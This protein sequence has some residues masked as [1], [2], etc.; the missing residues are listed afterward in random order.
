MAF[1]RRAAAFAM[2]LLVLAPTISVAVRI[3]TLRPTTV[4][5]ISQHVRELQAAAKTGG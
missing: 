3:A 4:N 5:Q 2:L 1:Y